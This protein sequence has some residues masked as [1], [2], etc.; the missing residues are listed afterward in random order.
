MSAPQTNLDKQKWWHRGPLIG[1]AVV[2]AFAFGLFVFMM[3]QVVD[4]GAAPGADVI[5]GVPQPAPEE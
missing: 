4:E 5:E 3:M 1:M 2:V